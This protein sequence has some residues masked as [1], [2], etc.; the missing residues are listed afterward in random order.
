MDKDVVMLNMPFTTPQDPFLLAQ[1]QPL[2]LFPPLDPSISLE[3]IDD[4]TIEQLALEI[5]IP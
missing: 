3:L 2:P 4:T 1:P 5:E